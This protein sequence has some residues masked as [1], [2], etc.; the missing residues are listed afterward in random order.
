MKLT[1]K[2]K[3]YLTVVGVGLAALVYDQMSA[4]PAQDDAASLLVTP[5]AI[6]ATRPPVN[7]PAPA[8]SAAP[9]TFAFDSVLVQRLDSVASERNFDFTRTRDA[10]VPSPSWIPPVA[11]NNSANPGLTNRAP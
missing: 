7:A 1:K 3:M 9:S 8:K 6:S 5:T 2:H 10:F 4:G 11:A